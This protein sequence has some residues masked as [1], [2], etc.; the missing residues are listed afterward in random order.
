[1]RSPIYTKSFCQENYREIIDVRSED[2]YKCDHIPGAINLPVLNN[3]ER[4]KVGT[5]YKQKS[6]FE[7]R[8]I[9]AAIVAKNISNHLANH[10]ISKDRE[11][12][13]LIYCWRGGQRSNSLATILSQIG[14]QVTVLEGG[15]KTYRAYIREQLSTLLSQFKLKI[16]SGLTGSGKTLIL[17]R[18]ASR[19][20]QVL[21]LERLAN[22]RGSLLG[23]EWSKLSS[24][25]W[26]ETTP[27]PPLQP[28]QKW[29]E[30]LLFSQL[31][32]FNP[33]GIVWVEAESNTIG[34]IHLPFPLWCKMKQASCVEIKLPLEIRINS[35]LQEYSHFISNP[36][37]LKSK[38]KLLKYR[39][40]NRKISYW[41]ELI[42]QRKWQELVKDLLTFH[43]DPAYQRSMN[44]IYSQIDQELSIEDL[45]QNSI[46]RAI[47]FLN[48]N[49]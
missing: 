20:E 23:E 36:E 31:Q 9:G 35:L 2:E 7:A 1:M 40:G 38:L 29:F 46:D 15:Y 17:Q 18:L 25:F 32:K 16:I 44:K 12:S 10:F 37:M 27:N 33:D 13:P 39:Y 6:P 28:S 3:I 41:Y 42:A 26:G 4:A 22:H 47:D 49:S 30:S 19:G 45:S 5:I 8:K 21:D 43:Y 14:W 34:E 24:P 11:Y 48:H